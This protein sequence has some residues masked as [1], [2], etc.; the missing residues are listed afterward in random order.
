MHSHN[1]THH[2]KG[3]YRCLKA[4]KALQNVPGLLGNSAA[5]SILLEDKPGALLYAA[6]ALSG[7]DPVGW[8][9]GLLGWMG[10]KRV[11]A[12]VQDTEVSLVL[13]LLQEDPSAAE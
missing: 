8:P 4:E 9:N 7:Q 11:H 6:Q 10:S 3:V 2:F 12:P 1:L 5:L 13:L